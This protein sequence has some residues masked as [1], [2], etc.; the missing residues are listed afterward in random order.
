MVTS[1]VM[2]NMVNTAVMDMARSMDMGMASMGIW[3]SN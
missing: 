1:T 2:V 3:R